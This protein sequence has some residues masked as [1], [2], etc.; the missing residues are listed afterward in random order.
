VP[1]WAWVYLFPYFQVPQ[2][3]GL[4]VDGNCLQPECPGLGPTDFL[5]RKESGP[6]EV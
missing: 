4:V 6:G 3:L 2:V 5:M 1:P